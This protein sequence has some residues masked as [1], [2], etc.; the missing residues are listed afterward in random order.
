MTQFKVG[1]SYFPKTPLVNNST[2]STKVNHSQN[3][4]KSF[5]VHLQQ[6]LHEP[7]IKFSQHAK[8]RLE[9]RG[10]DLSTELISR[11]N[12]GMKKA[13]EKGSHESLMIM[14][15][16]AFVVSVKNQTVITAMDQKSMADQVITNIDSA[17]LL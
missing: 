17:V 1:H 11:L 7:S 6:T 12:N 15:G 3:L 10:I 13:Q 8:V 4:N 14:E 5:A 2:T 16:L 9:E